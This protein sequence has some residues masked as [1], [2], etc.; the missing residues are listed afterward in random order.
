[1]SL[2]DLF[3]TVEQIAVR[4][5]FILHVETRLAASLPNHFSSRL[6]YF[7][8]TKITVQIAKSTSSPS[9]P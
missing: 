3:T 6:A 4:S 9:L 1:M 7:T 5:F 2:R 8:A